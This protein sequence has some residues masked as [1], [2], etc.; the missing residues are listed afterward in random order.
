MVAPIDA[1][2]VLTIGEGEEA[3][4]FTLV[5]NMRTLA[6]AKSLGINLLAMKKD[7]EID[8]FGMASIVQ[9]FATPAHP[10]I[11]AD[12]AFA[13]A[14]RHGEQVGAVIKELGEKFGAQVTE[15]KALPP[16]ARQA[17]AKA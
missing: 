1:K 5:M 17:K 6:L 15:G 13:I 9:A 16:K 14:L 4:R 8:A 7:Q 11:D 10:D 2:A 3:E 12:T